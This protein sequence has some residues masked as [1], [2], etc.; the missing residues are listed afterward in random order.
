MGFLLQLPY[1]ESRAPRGR[2]EFMSRTVG[3]I[4][5]GTIAERHIAAYR[6]LGVERLLLADIDRVRA[7]ALAQAWQLEVVDEPLALVEHPDIEAVDICTPTP[8][9]AGYAE[10]TL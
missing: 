10:A 1:L 9:H 4:G 3:I 2:G 6:E 5:A 7:A 8:S